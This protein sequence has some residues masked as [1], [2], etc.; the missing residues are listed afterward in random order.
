MKRIWPE[1]FCISLMDDSLARDFAAANGHSSPIMEARF[2][3]LGRYAAHT[4]ARADGILFTCS[5]FGAAIEAVKSDLAIPVVS[6][7]EGA[8]QEALDLCAHGT[9]GRIG[10]LLT[11]AASLGP[12]TAEIAQRA[13]ERRATAPDIAA[14]VVPEALTALQQGEPDE[15]DALLAKAAARLPVVDVLL[16]GQFSMARAA[17]AVANVRREPIVTTPT[18]AVGKLRRIVEKAASI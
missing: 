7:S 5:A 6:P 14:I 1:A 12:L 16:L 3:T 2:R 13:A 18:A 10:L 8:I 17:S 15:H 9:G 11:F 4:G